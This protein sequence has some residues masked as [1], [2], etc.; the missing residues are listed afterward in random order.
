MRVVKHWRG[1]PNAPSLRTFKVRLDGALSNFIKLK[2]SL[3]T[4]ER[5]DY[6]G[7]KGPFTPSVDVHRETEAGLEFI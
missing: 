7:W 6:I 5:L 3:L 4:V 2:M 1:L